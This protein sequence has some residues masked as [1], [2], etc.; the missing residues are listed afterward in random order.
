MVF[1]SSLRYILD[2]SR[3]PQPFP[4]FTLDLILLEILLHHLGRSTFK[5]QAFLASNY[6]HVRV[7]ETIVQDSYLL[8]TLAKAHSFNPFEEFHQKLL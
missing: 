7:R 1:L 4:L 3:I 6:Y 2:V 5:A 8:H